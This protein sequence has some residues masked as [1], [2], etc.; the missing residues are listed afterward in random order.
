MAKSKFKPNK[1]WIL[2]PDP[3]KTKTESGIF[4]DESTARKGATNII[5]CMEVGPKCVFVKK[6]D[7]I[8]IDPR[9]EAV[10]VD[11]DGVSHLLVQEF[12]VLGVL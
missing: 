9:T 2:L 6:G 7:T 10:V 12:Q 1:D 4:L 5:K 11:L 8:M 3:T